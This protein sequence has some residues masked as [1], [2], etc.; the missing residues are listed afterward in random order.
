LPWTDGGSRSTDAR[1]PRAASASAPSSNLRGKAGIG[2][3]LF[4]CERALALS[5]QGP[6]SD[7]QRAIRA[8]ERAAESL[9][10][11]LISLGGN[12]SLS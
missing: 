3:I 9:D 6:G 2:R 12:S 11:A 1:T 5:E 7:D 4:C 10:G 8:R